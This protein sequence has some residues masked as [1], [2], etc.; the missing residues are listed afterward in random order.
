MIRKFFLACLFL[1]G[2]TGAH[3]NAMEPGELIRTTS[4]E[5]LREFS[6]NRATYEA[7]RNSLYEMVNKIA[8]PHFDF[9]RM[10]KIVLGRH[11]KNATPEQRETFSFEF[12]TLLV[13]TYSQ[14]L[15]QYS[16]E[17]IKYIPAVPFRDDV[18]V[19]EEIDVGAA[20]PVRLEYFLG[21][22]DGD[23]KVFDVRIDGISL[24]TT[25]RKSYNITI[26]RKGLPVLIADL[27]KKNS[28]Q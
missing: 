28:M 15:F 10:T 19:R 8:I 18:M 21:K 3:A 23:W 4:E 7:D 16:N 20:V 11:Y 9:D 27:Q 25:F 1:L 17:K 5:L 24:V 6:A 13:R 14:A 26:S 22:K 2:T 12:K